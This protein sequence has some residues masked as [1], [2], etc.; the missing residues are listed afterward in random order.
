MFNQFLEREI[1]VS[2]IA[3]PLTVNY[4]MYYALVIIITAKRLAQTPSLMLRLQY[5]R[6]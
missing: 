3:L 4:Y 2:I 1:V 5:D 6:N